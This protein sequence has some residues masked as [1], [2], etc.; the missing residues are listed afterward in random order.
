MKKTDTKII[1]REFMPLNRYLSTAGV[2]SRRNAADYVKKGDV[3]VNGVVIVNPAFKVTDKDTVTFKNKLVRPEKKIYLLLNKPKDYITTRLD[4]RGR[5]T[6]MH[7]IKGDF[8]ERVY[9]VGRL[10]RATTGLLLI[11]NDGDLSQRLSHPRF[12]VKKIYNVSLDRPFKVEDIKEMRQGVKL[13]DG[14]IAADKIMYATVKSKKHVKIEIHSGKNRV[15]RRMFKYL[16]YN[17]LKLDRIN[18]AGLTK[19]G[20]PVGRWRKLTKNEIIYLKKFG[21]IKKHEKFSKKGRQD[22]LSKK[23]A[24]KKF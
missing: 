18:Y 11:T 6:V 9:P 21:D 8:K 24:K 17:V 23:V 1:E 20:L 10:D 22:G 7:L 16:G 14:F 2:C 12:E 13:R 3:K 15:V 19:K 4:E 5:K